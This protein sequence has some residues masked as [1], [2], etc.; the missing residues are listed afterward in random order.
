[1]IFKN[2]NDTNGNKKWNSTPP[3]ELAQITRSFGMAV[4][5]GRGGTKD[6]DVRIGESYRSRN[7]D[8][9]VRSTFAMSKFR[10]YCTAVAMTAS[11]FG[12]HGETHLPSVVCAELK[13]LS[14]AIED[15]LAKVPASEPSRNGHSPDLRLFG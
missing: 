12:N 3:I 13:L 5:A 6:L 8:L 7:G 2:Q 4:W 1:M 11:A 15:A 14:E 10:E 9:V